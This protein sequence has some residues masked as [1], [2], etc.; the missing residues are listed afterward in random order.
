LIFWNCFF[1]PRP[2]VYPITLAASTKEEIKWR[3]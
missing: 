1:N 3:F 2:L